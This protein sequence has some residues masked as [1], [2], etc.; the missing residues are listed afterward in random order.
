M[1]EQR[2]RASAMISW[3]ERANFFTVRSLSAEAAENRRG[4][5]TR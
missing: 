4:V 3:G 2:S 5:L 1:K